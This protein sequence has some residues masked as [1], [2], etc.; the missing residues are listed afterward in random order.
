[1]EGTLP[2]REA[3]RVRVQGRWAAGLSGLRGGLSEL[4]G[5]VLPVE[6][7]GCG[8]PGVRVCARCTRE[9][10]G[11]PWRLV[12]TA[13]A[14]PP[15]AV[16]WAAVPYSGEVR[17]LVVAWK[18]RGRHDLGGP[19]ADA[20]AHA[21]LALLADLRTADATQGRPVRAGHPRSGVGSPRAGPSVLLVPVPS[22]RWA[23]AERGADVVRRLALL[24][25][26]RAR[27]SGACV[28]VLPALSLGRSVA[29]QAGLGRAARAQNVAGA[30]RVR[31]GARRVVGCRACIVVD[32]VVTTGATALEA[33]RALR[34]A[35]ALPVGVAVSC[36]TPL[37]RGLSDVAHLH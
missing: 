26:R 6:C 18:D 5:A 1:V 28:R 14:L 25:A 23:R 29:D 32:D 7:G 35:G 33:V 20:L 11:P 15:G 31:A 19:L 9:L 2:G 36:A 21:V 3:E 8:E 4:G 37:H 30:M 34:A 24:A 22:S 17:R 13:G 12:L 10:A 27:S 16:A